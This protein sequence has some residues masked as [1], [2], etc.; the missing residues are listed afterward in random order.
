MQQRRFFS[1]QNGKLLR[2]CADDLNRATGAV[3]DGKLFKGQAAVE[4]T[5]KLLKRKP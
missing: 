2:L 4:A 3:I 5:A 1:P